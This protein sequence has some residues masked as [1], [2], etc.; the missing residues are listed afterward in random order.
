[1][2]R[3]DNFIYNYYNEF[4]E[5]EMGAIYRVTPS[6]L[7][8]LYEGCKRC[9][10]LKVRHNLYRPSTPMPSIFNS[11]AQAQ[12]NFIN[13]KHTS[14]TGL[15]LPPGTVEFVECRVE[16][17]PLS[18]P[19]M[20]SRL[21]IHGRLDIAI[22]LDAGGYAVFDF[23][24]ARPSESLSELYA[25]QLHAYA[26]ALENAKEGVLNLEPVNSIGL[27]YFD[28]KTFDKDRNGQF[29]LFGDVAVVNIERDDEEFK[30]FLV[31]V[32]SLLEDSKL[33]NPS[34]NCKWCKYPNQLGSF[35]KASAEDVLKCPKCGA[36]ME[37]KH[38]RNGWFWS[39]SRWPECNGSLNLEREQRPSESSKYEIPPD[40][41][42]YLVWLLG[43][44]RLYEAPEEGVDQEILETA[45]RVASIIADPSL[46]APNSDEGMTPLHFLVEAIW[47]MI[48]EQ[49]M[50]DEI[51][52]HE[53]LLIDQ[54][55]EA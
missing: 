38:G 45:K 28:P 31:E 44:C 40:D 51:K 48:A 22:R 29:G 32:L 37:L 35:S 36:D 34:D 3:L 54:M 2:F 41:F 53:D 23:K 17:K 10:V 46:R 11:I 1:M 47:T 19:G 9:F 52:A 6:D 8:Y 25:R 18:I 20:K 16:S 27:I 7:T 15:P 33:P 50:L 4:S 12:V 26:W 21:V 13:G 49:R 39:C 24:T 55:R 14:A 30:D 43:A 5:G 42:E